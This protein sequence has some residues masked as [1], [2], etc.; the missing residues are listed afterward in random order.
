LT[1]AFTSSLQNFLED[2]VASVIQSDEFN[3]AWVA[4]NRVAHRAVLGVLRYE[5]ELLSLE[6]G[7]LA[8]DLSG[9]FEFVQS[10]LGLEDLPLFA[11]ENWGRFVLLESRQVALLQEALDL[12]DSIGLLLPLLALIVLFLAWLVSLWR[13]STVLWIGIGSA[14]AMVISLIVFYL[15]RPVLTVS[16]ADP[17]VRAIAREIWD[18]VTRPLVIQTVILF[19]VAV[20]LAAGA[21]LAGPSPRAAATRA[22]FGRQYDG[23]RARVGRRASQ[24]DS[25]AST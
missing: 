20:L 16:I 14:I 17:L 9:I 25:P 3:A 22:W 10:T 13:R 5:G 2:T 24:G 8:V 15:L 1:G 11:Q 12:V 21:A 4:V 7:Q 23:L 18:A 19:F 6:G